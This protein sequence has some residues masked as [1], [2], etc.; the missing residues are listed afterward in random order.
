MSGYIPDLMMT[1]RKVNDEMGAW[2]LENFVKF[3]KITP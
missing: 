1:A 3:T 2:A